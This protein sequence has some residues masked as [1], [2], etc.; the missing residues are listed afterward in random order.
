MKM[1]IQSKGNLI[2][3][4]WII[5]FATMISLKMCKKLTN[6]M[7]LIFLLE[8]NPDEKLKS[9][10]RSLK[11]NKTKKRQMSMIISLPI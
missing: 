2:I 1:I 11:A 10:P 8:V 4:K 9:R 5:H 6:S 3:D 7:S